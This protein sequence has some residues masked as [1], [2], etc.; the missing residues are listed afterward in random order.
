MC[1][2]GNYPEAKGVWYSSKAQFTVFCIILIRIKL[3][4]LVCSWLTTSR[5]CWVTVA[6]I[7]M[8]SSSTTCG[9]VSSQD[10]NLQRGRMLRLVLHIEAPFNHNSTT[11]TKF[12]HNLQYFRFLGCSKRRGVDAII[13][14]SV[15]GS[16]CSV[17][18]KTI[19]YIDVS[20]YAG[21]TVQCLRLSQHVPLQNPQFQCQQSSK[22][23][24]KHWIALHLIPLNV[25]SFWW[26][27]HPVCRE[28]LMHCIGKCHE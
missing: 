11:E 24:K 7:C 14:R 26:E 4:S 19:R 1:I 17:S 9:W 20:Y 16:G 15:S 8:R 18:L 2:H 12:K 5:V 10:F 27:K 21:V 23:L 13:S 28:I 25:S 6:I 3:L 22:S